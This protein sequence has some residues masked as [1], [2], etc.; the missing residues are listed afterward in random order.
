MW[1]DKNYRWSCEISV[2]EKAVVTVQNV[3][4]TAA[5]KQRLDLDTIV[6]LFPETQYRPEEFPGLVFRLRKPKTAT[7]IFSSG[8]MVCTGS[9]SERQARKAV[10][11]VMNELK[12]NGIVVVGSPEIQVQ[13]IVAS[14]GFGGSID[15]EKT[16]YS[17]ERTMYEPEQFPGLI[18]RMDDPKVVMLLFASGNFVCTGAKKEEE[19]HRAITMLQET[20]ENKKLITYK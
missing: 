20:L 11:T 10:A 7:L 6:R 19:V 14:G 9:K 18:Y 16:T 8:K 12:R 3:V 15:L 13:N 1:S 2:K 5:L 17:L 4:A